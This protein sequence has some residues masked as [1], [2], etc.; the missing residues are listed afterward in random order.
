MSSTPHLALPLLAAAQAQKHVTHNEA[1]SCLDALVHLSVKERNRTAPP[2]TPE[3]G[4]RYLV[5]AGATGAFSGQQARI[6]LFDLGAW[7]FLVPR[8]GWRAYVEAEDAIVVFDGE[9]WHDLGRYCRAIDHLDRLGLGTAPDDLNRFSAKL[10]A[11]LFAALSPEEGGTGDLR[12]VLNKAGT[13]NVL[14]QLYQ[15]GFS[16]RAETGLIGSDDF[17]IRISP[18]GAEW[19]DALLL[20]GR[21]GVGTFPQGLSN[22]PRANLL[23][24]SSFNVNQRGFS[25]GALAEGV[26]GFDRWKGGP[27]GCTLTRAPD[28]TVTLAGALDQVIDMD[29]ASALTGTAGLAGAVLTLSVQDPSAPLPVTIGSAEATIE[30]GSG[31]RSVSVALGGS[32][33][34]HVLVRLEP[35]AACSFR[36]VKL[37]IGAYATPWAGEP[38][39][40]EEQLCRRYYQ[41]LPASGSSPRILGAFGQR[42]TVNMIDFPVILPTPMRADPTVV[43][44]GAAWAGGIPG[45]NQLAF[46]SNSN[47]AWLTTSGGVNVTTVGLASA[48]AVVLRLQAVTFFSGATG[49]TGNLYLGNTAVLALQAEL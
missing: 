46:Y 36:N 27:G 35:T 29:H 34:G 17:S 8:P 5:G 42:V 40:R 38:L 37:E 4:D 9:E 23:I 2:A 24:N 21:T 39:D 43:A 7:R 49:A 16:G 6:A 31:R 30:A 13:A 26:Y 44:S 15:R 18:D 28:G 19:T 45:G 20:D 10:N 33:T 32:E 14:S 12:F 25:G 1:L 3:E 47:A 48:S 11:A 22:V 41:P